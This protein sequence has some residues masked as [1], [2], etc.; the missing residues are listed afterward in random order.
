MTSSRAQEFVVPHVPG[1]AVVL[2][3][4]WDAGSASVAEANGFVD[5]EEMSIDFALGNAKR[6]IHAAD[7]P[8]AVD[9]EGDE[10]QCR[11]G[12]RARAKTSDAAGHADRPRG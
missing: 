7:V 8:I 5:G 10:I 3:S 2:Y 9:F 12:T 4:V 6:I 1:N 11:E